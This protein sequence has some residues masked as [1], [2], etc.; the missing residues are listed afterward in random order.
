MPLKS[1]KKVKNDLYTPVSRREFGFLF[2]IAFYAH[3]LCEEK[4]FMA[5]Q[6]P[7]DPNLTRRKRDLKRA[8]E[9]YVKSYT[10]I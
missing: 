9:K 3:V 10:L 8:V 6:A 4:E 5:S 7:A 1:K 2:N